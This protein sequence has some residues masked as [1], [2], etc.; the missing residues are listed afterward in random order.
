VIDK[1]NLAARADVRSFDFRTLRIAHRE[2]PNLQTVAL[3]GDDP[4]YGGSCSTPPTASRSSATTPR[5]T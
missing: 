3:W 2:F 1:Y 5:A 4:A